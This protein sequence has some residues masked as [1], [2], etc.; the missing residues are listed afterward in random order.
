MDLLNWQTDK[1]V[2]GTAASGG[3]EAKMWV[4]G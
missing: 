1:D 2:L 3:A 4:V